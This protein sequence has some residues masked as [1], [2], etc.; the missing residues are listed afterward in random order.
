MIKPIQFAC[1]VILT[2]VSAAGC[3]KT[4]TS[5]SS[6]LT[7]TC[8]ASQTALSG[9]GRPV[10][11][12]FAS[13]TVSGGEGAVTTVCSPASGTLFPVGPSTV[14]CSARDARQQTATCSLGV[15]V[16]VGQTP[17]ISVTAFTAFGDSI[18]AGQLDPPCTT[19]TAV[20]SLSAI[21]ADL[22]STNWAIV[23]SAAYPTKL[24]Q[25]L[26]ARYPAQSVLVSN[27]GVAG[28][29]VPQGVTRLPAVL[30]EERPHVLLLQ[31]GVNGLSAS[32][33]APMITGLRTMIRDAKSRGAQVMIGTLLP[34]R[35]GACRAFAVNDIVPANTAIRQL[36]GEE[37][38]ALVDLYQAFGG[39]AG[40]LIGFDGLHPN[41][42]GYQKI[43]DTFFA[44]IRQRF[45]V[46]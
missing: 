19:L 22:R 45:E 21:L 17:R 44:A 13:P 15:T 39:E 32:A 41:E 31:E 4:P 43:A 10:A 46:P 24:Q 8:A 5:P 3:G 25:L 35:A 18:T 37:N 29:T 40:S 36:A 6:P 30:A 27:R 11:V 20:P 2:A 1:A 28:E 9:D 33:I 42:A 16:G 7:L 12:T 23:V 38:A 34:Q 14:T 26:A